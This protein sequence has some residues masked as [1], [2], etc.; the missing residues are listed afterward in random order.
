MSKRP[1]YS[2]NKEI[3]SKLKDFKAY[4]QELGNGT[5]TIR[6]KSNYT[7]YFLNWLESERLQPQETRYN[8]LLNFIDYCKLEGNSKKHIN[9]KLRSIRNYYEYL[10]KLNPKIISPAA[11]LYLKGTHKKTISGIID[12][13]ALENLYQ[14]F[15]TTTNREKRNKI[16]LGLLIYQGVTTEELK[17]LEPGHLKLKEGKIYIPGNRRRNSRKLDLKSFQI[18]ELHEYLTETRTKILNEITEPR[19]ARKPDKINKAKLENQLFIS[20]NGSENIKNS[21]LHMFKAIQKTNPEIL[22]P[23]QIRA[24]VITHWLKNHNLRQV[25]Y[26]AGHKYVSSTE[27]Y[28]MNNLDN[29]QS[30]LDKLHPLNRTK[31][32]F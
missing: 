30:K 11:N 23:K 8:D 29:L 20:I 26:M 2:F 5:N 12:F 32:E 13:A 10:K 18:L 1:E 31:Y 6:Q 14:T 27:R 4:L 19:P 15:E 25:Q 7:G 17:Q 16:I 28:Q 21:L 24:S 9:S 3:E 22:H